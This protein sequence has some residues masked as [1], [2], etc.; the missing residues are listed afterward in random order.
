MPDPS[1]PGAPDPTAAAI[2]NA[3][4]RVLTQKGLKGATT[5]AI[6]LE[7]GV[8]EVTLF[9]RYG[10]KTGLIHAAILSRAGTVQQNAV[11]YT[12]NLEAD[13][14]HLTRE[15]LYALETVG[16][17]VRVM[18]TEFPQHP[19]LSSVLDG[20]RLLFRAIAE[21][22]T[23]Y[24]QAGQLQPEPIGTLLPAF[25]GPLVLP[26]LLPGV[27]PLI[28]GENMPPLDPAE[29][30]TRFLHGRKGEQP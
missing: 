24:Q 2:L 3:V 11:Q 5:R 29:H 15:Y 17:V 21:L 28:L 22:L 7:A 1:A 6:A 19:E 9:R 10:N 26:Y 8:N 30:V 14:L 16:P 13:L 18:V 27:V 20:P 4:L 23:R 12:G 25:I